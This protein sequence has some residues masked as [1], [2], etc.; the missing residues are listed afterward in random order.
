MFRRGEEDSSWWASNA[1]AEPLVAA[2]AAAMITADGPSGGGAIAGNCGALLRRA[3][4]LLLLERC[5]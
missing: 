2:L 3:L 5:Q 1:L 4:T